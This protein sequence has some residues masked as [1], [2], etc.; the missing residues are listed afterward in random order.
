MLR[1]ECLGSAC[2]IVLLSHIRYRYWHEASLVNHNAKASFSPSLT[3]VRSPKEL[4]YGPHYLEITIV[5]Q[6]WENRKDIR[7][8]AFSSISS[9][10]I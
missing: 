5:S 1:S 9:S 10:V 6:Y 2:E 8:H 7:G 3:V 4:W